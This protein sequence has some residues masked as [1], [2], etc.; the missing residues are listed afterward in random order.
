MKNGYVKVLLNTITLLAIL[1]VMDETIGWAGEKYMI[2]LSRIPRNGDSALVNYNLN[3]A[4]PDVAI[5]GSSTAI[6]H[7]DPVK[8]HDSLKSYLNE[9]LEVFNMGMS[10]QRLTYD[11]YGLKCLLERTQP[12][13]VF[14]DVW[15]SYI[16]T[17]DPS[18][19]FEAYRPYVNINHNVKEML[20]KHDKYDFLMKSNLYCYNTELFKLLM[21]ILKKPNANGF[22]N[23][24]VEMREVVKDKERDTTD[25]LP[26]S[27]DEFNA[28]L[29]LVKESKTT[30]FV[31]LS[32]TLRSADTTSQSYQYMKS[33]CIENGI[34]FLDYSNNT[35]Y[36]D[37]HYFRDKTHMNYYGA[38][39]FTGNLMKDISMYLI[40]D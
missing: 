17:G 9:D 31:V 14:V 18:T 1:F 15:A 7:Y 32:P 12:K 10:N 11:Y 23:S 13:M 20:M 6:C 8:I 29:S 37:T 4:T 38:E 36:Y 3:T 39:L 27:I 22:I 21:S 25:L 19:S 28:M 26:L 2:W 33:Q 16:G 34:P 30:M 40:E 24:M 5:I 35:D